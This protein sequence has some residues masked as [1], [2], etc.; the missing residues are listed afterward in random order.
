[1]KTSA[2]TPLAVRIIFL[3][4]LCLATTSAHAQTIAG[5]I[6]EPG[7][8]LYGQVRNTATGNSLLTYGTLR[9]TITPP[10][11]SAIVV[12]ATLTN[13]ND[14]FSY[15][16]RVPFETVISGFTVSS[17]ALALSSTPA[18]YSRSA[19]VSGTLS[20]TQQSATIVSPALGT[21]S[22]GA[23]D[24]GGPGRGRI[25][26]V[27]LQVSLPIVDTDANGLDDNWEKAYFGH[28]G[29][30]PNADPDHDGMKNSAELKAGTNPN[31]PNSRFA[32]VGVGP[33]PLGGVAIQWS[34]VALQ[35]YT[36]QRSSDLITSFTNLTTGIDATP[37]TNYVRDA[38]AV[39]S[40][41]FFYRIRVE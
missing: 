37:G 26:H 1:M 23:V 28:L 33:D 18:S 41:P 30:D 13:I 19:T 3:V 34:S 32:F 36:I 21:F 10:V 7:L 2:H 35:K 15:I 12:T 5:A 39:G 38:T 11:G 16:V 6:P 20:G 31:D 4:V 9:W 22:F 29:V 27:D 17:G 24:G 8:I 14:Q 40:G 25:E